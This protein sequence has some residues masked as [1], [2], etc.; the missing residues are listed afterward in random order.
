[1]HYWNQDE[2]EDNKKKFK[3]AP[4]DPRFPNYNQGS[5]HGWRVCLWAAKR[6][7]VNYVDFYKC[8]AAKGDSD[9]VCATFQFAFQEICPPN[10]VRP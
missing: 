6:C 4:Y 10:F 2:R 3:T 8:A 7:W 9:P 1:M 5:P